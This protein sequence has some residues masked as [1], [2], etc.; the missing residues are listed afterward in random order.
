MVFV[1]GF[2]I[3]LL[4]LAIT[5]SPAPSASVGSSKAATEQWW[6]GPSTEITK[7]VRKADKR[8]YAK[9]QPKAAKLAS[10]LG[11]QLRI[12]AVEVLI[13]PC[14]GVWTGRTRFVSQANAY[15]PDET[16]S[17]VLKGLAQRMDQ[18]GL[19]RPSKAQIA[20]GGW[21]ST[22]ADGVRTAVQ[23]APQGEEGTRAT[24]IV[25][26]RCM[27]VAATPTTGKPAPTP[28][29]SSPESLSTEPL[30]AEAATAAT[31]GS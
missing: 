20:Q 11:S 2:S 12:P 24:A 28:T 22:D 19:G 10:Q 23:A 5:R 3:G 27:A 26:T 15:V 17:Q 6:Y 30:S 25:A 16:P 1:A 18:L 31:P 8:E 29:T 7:D 13:Q 9:V 4:V 14:G 21:R